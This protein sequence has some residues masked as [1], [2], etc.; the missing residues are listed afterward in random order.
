MDNGIWATWYDIAPED[1]QRFNDWLHAIYLPSL[2][3]IPGYAWVAQYFNT[4][5]GQ[6]MVEYEKIVTR[7]TEE[8]GEGGQY[9]ILVGAASPHTFFTPYFRDLAERPEHREMLALR[10]GVRTA[11]FAEEARI[12]GPAAASYRPGSTPAPAIQFGSYRVKSVE[13]EFGLAQWYAQYRFPH[14]AQMPGCVMTRKLLCVAGWVKHGIL[15]EFESLEARMKYFEEPHEA[16][17]LDPEEW[18]GK[19]FRSTIHTPG[20]PVIGERRWPPCRV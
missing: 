7:P 15:Y 18:T 1:E 5:G 9:V 12:N 11:I 14:M 13:Q 6:A 8:I 17:A 3:S 4:R 19:I 2:Q 10:K 16:L 20:S